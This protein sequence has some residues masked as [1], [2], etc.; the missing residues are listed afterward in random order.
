MRIFSR[1]LAAAILFVAAAAQAATTPNSWITAQTPTEGRVQFLQGTDS[2]GTYK[3][4]YTAG[5]NGS[6]CLALWST[7]N[8]ASATHLLTVQ[9]VNGG[10]K[11]G[12][13]SLTT[14]SNAGFA[15]GTPPQNLLAAAVWPGLAQDGN[16]NPF[17]MLASGD[18]LQET[19]AT[20]LTSTDLINT[21]A[22]CED[23]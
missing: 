19:F 2:A 23:F 4:V 8:D 14:V 3:T 15:N 18:T 10:V 12:G 11:Y 13:T 6:R 7:N 20:A 22:T 1:A 5:T 17:I 16:G 21:I 9:I